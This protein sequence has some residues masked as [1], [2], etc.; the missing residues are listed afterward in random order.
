MQRAILIIK[1][2]FKTQAKASL[3]AVILS[4]GVG[5]AFAYYGYGVWALVIQAI[6]SMAIVSY[7]VRLWIQT[8]TIRLVTH[9]IHEPV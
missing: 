1:L 3:I 4:G 5:I 2:D 6:A 8:I 9:D 7:I